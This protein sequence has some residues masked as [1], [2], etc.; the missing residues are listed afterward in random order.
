MTSDFLN[1]DFR[2]LSAQHPLSMVRL[3]VRLPG[4]SGIE[5]LPEIRKIAGDLR[6][7][8]ITA[9]ADLRQAVDAMKI[10]ADD[11]LAK[12]VECQGNR[13]HAAKKLGISRRALIYKLRAIETETQ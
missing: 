10:G 3:D 6:V 8:L 1:R 13:T 11:Y 7:L 2:H 5:A 4:K 12:P 9:F